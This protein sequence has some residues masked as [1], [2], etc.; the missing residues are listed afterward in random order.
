[1]G[2]FAG[3]SVTMSLPGGITELQNILLML[4]F[5]DK[6]GSRP[7]NPHAQTKSVVAAHWD[8]ICCWRGRNFAAVARAVWASLNCVS[9]LLCGQTT[10][11]RSSQATGRR[12]GKKRAEQAWGMAES[13]RD[14]YLWHWVQLSSE[15]FRDS[16]YGH[17][18]LLQISCSCL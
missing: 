10:E 15:H 14:M 11:A 16:T 5:G 1:M 18:L 13:L 12:K 6:Q 8:W 7:M 3:T 4:D 9:S 17:Q 2:Y